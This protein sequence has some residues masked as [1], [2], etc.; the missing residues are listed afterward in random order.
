MDKNRWRGK[1]YDE[2]FYIDDRGGVSSATEILSQTSDYRYKI[3]NY[4]KCTADAEMV[5][6][7]F[8]YML[9]IHAVN[10]SEPLISELTKCRSTK[11]LQ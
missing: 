3:G 9:E 4:F 5:R 2:Y 1:K 7:S 6:D 10:N 8:L 11:T